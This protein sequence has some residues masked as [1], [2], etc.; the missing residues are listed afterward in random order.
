MTNGLITTQTQTAC[1]T[2]GKQ[3]DTGD[4]PAFLIFVRQKRLFF[5]V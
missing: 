1:N 4:A 3:D 2:N 5:G